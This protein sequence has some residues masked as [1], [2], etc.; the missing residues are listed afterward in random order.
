MNTELNDKS[1]CKT[2]QCS[3]GKTQCQMQVTMVK[4]DSVHQRINQSRALH[5]IVSQK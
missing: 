1:N 5:S 3:G 2:M 4:G